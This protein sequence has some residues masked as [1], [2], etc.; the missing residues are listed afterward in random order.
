VIQSIQIENYRGIRKGE[1]QDLPRIA[2]LTG[3][4]GCGKS[5]VLEAMQIGSSAEGRVHRVLGRW[6]GLVSPHR[7]LLHRGELG[8]AKVTV[9]WDDNSWIRKLVTTGV[10]GA[11]DSM[12]RAEG[13]ITESKAALFI[14]HRPGRPSPALHQLFTDTRRRGGVEAALKLLAEV[15]PSIRG[16]EILTEG[17]QPILHIAYDDRV[18][19]A[20]LAGD[21]MSSLV[22]LA[23]ELSQRKDGTFLI[24]E[25][26][27]HQHSA[28]IL[29]SARIV[30]A[31]A[32]LGSQVLLSTHSM[33][34]LD[35]LLA[36][37]RDDELDLLA[38]YRLRLVQGELKV[39]RMPGKEVHAARTEIE[40]D[41]R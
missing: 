15:D 19:P 21:G 13:T 41:L 38:V 30:V 11:G 1:L 18:V 16:L 31:A 20:A 17:D 14:E 7:W 39:L 34:L 10:G 35:D 25:P 29:R 24:E 23:L 36:A 37:L 22:R 28:A 9:R 40:D 8:Q 4:N 12:D 5:S 33:E 32:R 2:V 27:A 3:P 26:E 6:G